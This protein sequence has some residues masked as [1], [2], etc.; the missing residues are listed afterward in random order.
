MIAH[1]Q[2]LK[3]LFGDVSNAFVTTTTSEK[4][5]CIVSPEFGQKQGMTVIIEKA[6]Y[7]L[8][9]SAARFHNHLADTFPS[10]NFNPTRFDHDVWIRSNTTK[11][12]YDYICTHVDEFCIFSKE[13][14]M[15]VDKIKKIYQV[16]SMSSPSYYLGNDFK[17][18]SQGR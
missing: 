2:N 15:I 1:S 3:V 5:Y 11:D 13:L 12:G 16:K 17:R 9:T 8:T 4:V 10:L 14:S 18:D 6:L 7:G